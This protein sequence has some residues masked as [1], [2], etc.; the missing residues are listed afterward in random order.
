MLSPHQKNTCK[1]ISFPFLSDPYK[2]SSCCFKKEYIATKHSH[3]NRKFHHHTAFE[4]H[5]ILEGKVLY[6]ISD[7]IVSLEEGQILLI[8]PKTKHRI[9]DVS[10]EVVKSSLMLSFVE[11]RNKDI[12]ECMS[13]HSFYTA[14]IT[15]EINE[16]I[17]YLA[18]V[19]TNDEVNGAFTVSAKA[20]S[21]ICSLPFNFF[22]SGAE[23]FDRDEIDVRL[24]DAK[25][26]IKD[27]LSLNITCKQVAQH[28]YLSVKQLSRIFVKYE[29]MTLMKYI[30]KAKTDAAEQLLV[31]SDISLK[32]ISE[33]LGFCNEY[34]FNS[35]F[36]K[37]SGMSPGDYRKALK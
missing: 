18:T 27:N 32:E 4:I 25:Q 14:R 11:T 26:Y 37:N 10:D 21:L 13:A 1:Q 24:S 17:Q 12:L 2:I 19:K 15:A 3:V 34:Y 7:E 16:L 28:C 33:K 29:G 20:Y 6:E 22:N 35:F 31:D 5:F 30:V 8:L 23:N 9:V 36:K